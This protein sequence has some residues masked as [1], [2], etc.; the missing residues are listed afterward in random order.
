MTQ[1]NSD[2]LSASAMTSLAPSLSKPLATRLIRLLAA[3]TVA[4]YAGAMSL[5]HWFHEVPVYYT[6]MAGTLGFVLLFLAL[7]AFFSGKWLGFFTST[8]QRTCPD[9]LPILLIWSI[10]F[11]IFGCFALGL[12][13][14][15]VQQQLSNGLAL[16]LMF[17]VAALLPLLLGRVAPWITTDKLWK[18]LCEAWYVLT[19][20]IAAIILFWMINT[21]LVNHSS[22][23]AASASA[24]PA[25]GFI[26]NPNAPP[27]HSG[28]ESDEDNTCAPTHTK[29][30]EANADVAAPPLNQ[31]YPLAG[32][33]LL[34]FGGVILLLGRGLSGRDSSGLAS[35][36]AK[37]A[38][39]ALLEKFG[40]SL[41]SAHV[42]GETALSGMLEKAAQ[43]AGGN[44]AAEAAA[45][46]S[47][48]AV[49]T[50]EPRIEVAPA[51]PAAPAAAVAPPEPPISAA[52]APALA[53]PATAPAAPAAATPATASVVVK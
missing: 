6:F 44:F 23:K 4:L 9:W 53:A 49:V 33:G 3:N 43:T 15:Q 47:A 42:A 39:A 17:I 48:V 51:A 45:L 31:V 32:C 13:D 5:L 37:M 11:S 2:M 36:A 22:V 10:G 40:S 20:I 18:K 1:A 52:P 12:A 16:P 27:P 26:C 50:P 21:A 25:L 14:A 29:P 38:E 35:A 19:T 8:A 41:G 28:D 7:G 30:A 24:M 34:L 46:T